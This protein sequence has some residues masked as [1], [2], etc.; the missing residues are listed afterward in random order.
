MKKEPKFLFFFLITLVG[1]LAASTVFFAAKNF[2]PEPEDG[3]KVPLSIEVTQTAKPAQTS[4]V[5]SPASSSEKPSKVTDTYTVQ[6][7]ETL[8]AVAQ[9]QGTTWTELAEANGL[10]DVNKIQAGQVLIIPKGG[11][12]NFVLDNTL[13]TNI[14][15]EVEAGRNQFRL[16]PEETARTDAPNVYGLKVTDT[17]TIKSKD[18]TKGE[19]EVLATREDKNYLIKLIQ[20]MTKGEKGIW[21][22]EFI[23]PV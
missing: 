4:E 2:K 10:T 18:E 23:R 6:K 7:G 19:A 15:K 11:K 1:V 12:V 13:A 16:S 20:P 5:L 17:L 14:Q 9:A 8:F 22:I 21:A 3:G